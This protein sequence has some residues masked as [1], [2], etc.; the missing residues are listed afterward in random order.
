[1]ATRLAPRS[2]PPK[3]NEFT[4]ADRT[5]LNSIEFGANVGGF[6]NLEEDNVPV[7][8]SEET[9]NFSGHVMVT[10]Q[11]FQTDIFIPLDL[12]GGSF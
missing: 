2:R 7:T 1:M 6:P 8:A 11:G 3:P 9:I 4:L 12:D 10:D 5:K